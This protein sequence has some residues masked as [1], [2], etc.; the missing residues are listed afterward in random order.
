MAKGERKED[1]GIKCTEKET[2]GKVKE[3]AGVRT[4]KVVAD[5]VFPRRGDVHSSHSFHVGRTDLVRDAIAKDRDVAVR[6]V[7]DIGR[8]GKTSRD[9][10][11]RGRAKKKRGREKPLSS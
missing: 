11:T 10:G 6:D 1:E 3:G 7:L 2:E 9:F 5:R 8:R 4:F